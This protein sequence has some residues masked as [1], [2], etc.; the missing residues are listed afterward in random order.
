[1]DQAHIAQFRYDPRSM[2]WSLWWSDRNGKWLRV[3]DAPSA[4]DVD[5]LL[6]I[7]AEN[8]TGAFE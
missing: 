5:P 2:T 7:V 1:M 4:G 3:L 6:R 8:H